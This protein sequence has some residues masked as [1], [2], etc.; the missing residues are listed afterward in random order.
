MKI[1]NQKL[2]PLYDKW[3]N[4]V[5]CKGSWE[6]LGEK[7]QP[8]TETQTENMVIMLE[9]MEQSKI[10]KESTVSGD[11]AIWNPVLIP[12][13]RRIMPAL[14][15][16][17]IMG[18]QPLRLPTGLIFSVRAEYQGSHAD[19][20]KS[21]E[22]VILTVESG[23]DFVIGSTIATA[24]GAVGVIKYLEGVNALVKM[25]TGTFASGEEVDNVTP[26]A[27]A[28]TEIVS[29][30][31]NE[32]L[33]KYIFK[34][35]TGT[36]TTAQG[37]YLGVNTNEM[38]IKIES[39]PVEAKS[40]KL[41]ARWSQEL[42]EDLRNV[43]NLD[44]EALLS[45]MATD[46][47]TLEMNR[48][49]IDMAH[50]F[51]IQGGVTPWSYTAADGRWEVEKYQNL[52]ATISRVRRKVEL[53]NRRGP[54]NFMIVTPNVLSALESTGKLASDIAT[55]NAMGG[56]MVKG[57]FAGVYGAVGTGIKVFV[58]IFANTTSS[59]DY[60]ILGYK[61]DETDAGFYFAPYVPVQMMKGINSEDGTPRLFFRTRYGVVE[62]PFSAK[63]Y[64]QKISIT[65]LPQ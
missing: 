32:A 8:L 18:V 60:I 42:E 49:F 43:H 55:F 37:E 3:E 46:E 52:A 59:E 53:A 39:L 28:K 27:A 56:S 24:A 20:Y 6:F 63:N 29:V 25:T 57:T 61:G 48:E 35:Y 50:G 40:R 23:A 54:A 4:I 44:A 11:V 30:N 65:G 9:N 7:C 2:A 17:E 12:M 41:K 1:S 31:R 45:N 36:M 15:A 16:N 14:I 21:S 51:A 58:D 26:F 62:N 19:S 47:I 5:E 22:T 10:L 38:G 34:N 13:V 33:F 64:F